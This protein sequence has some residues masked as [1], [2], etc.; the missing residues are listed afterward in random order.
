MVTHLNDAI[1]RGAFVL[2]V[3]I[4]NGKWKEFRASYPYCPTYWKKINLNIY[5]H[6]VHILL[7]HVALYVYVMYLL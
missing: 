3:R 5:P 7:E 6:V 4:S 1:M 2:L